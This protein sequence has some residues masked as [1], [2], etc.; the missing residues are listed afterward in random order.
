MRPQRTSVQW[1]PE[2]PLRPA[3]VSGGRL[4]ARAWPPEED[5]HGG[6]PAAPHGPADDPLHDAGKAAPSA[7]ILGSSPTSRSGRSPPF[8]FAPRPPGGQVR[9]TC[10]ARPGALRPLLSASAQPSKKLVRSQPPNGPL[11][12]RLRGTPSPPPAVWL[13]PTGEQVGKHS[14]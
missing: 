9:S 7:R 11:L 14:L 3:G 13:L 5:T 4:H 10:C 6:H 2:G 1:G 12:P 8:L